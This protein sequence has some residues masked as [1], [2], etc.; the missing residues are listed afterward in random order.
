MTNMPPEAIIVGDDGLPIGHVN[1]D[2]LTADATLLMYDM[3]VTAGDD[4][5]T[6]KVAMKWA[7][8]HEPDYFGYLCA[9]ALSL[10]TRHILGPT[11]DVTDRVGVDLRTGLKQASAAA[12]RDLQ[13]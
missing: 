9:S 1:F 8:A 2:Q 11:L 7:G 13:K 5:A 4:D 6:D 3:A 12:H 10:M